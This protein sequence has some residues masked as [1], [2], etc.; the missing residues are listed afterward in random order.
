MSPTYKF[1]TML[2]RR[3]LN[4]GRALYRGLVVA[5]LLV[6]AADGSVCA[7]MQNNG[8]SEAL[9][10]PVNFGCTYP[11][12]CNFDDAALLDDG[13][14]DFTCLFS[15]VICG[16]GTM[17]LAAW[18]ACVP[19]QSTCPTDLNGDATTDVSDLLIFLAMFAIPCP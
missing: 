3:H 11:A 9:A 6:A 10:L 8:L 4:G 19:A 17:W 15:D 7:Q 16:P 18:Q 12:A 2:L 14:C 5:L 1:R 13:S